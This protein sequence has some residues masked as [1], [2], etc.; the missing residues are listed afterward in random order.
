MYVSESGC[1]SAKG[2]GR[3]GRFLLSE[4][5]QR[6]QWQPVAVQCCLVRHTRGVLRSSRSL[7]RLLP[8][9]LTRILLHAD[10]KPQCIRDGKSIIIEGLHIDPGLFLLEFGDS[11]GVSPTS[12]GGGLDLASGDPRSSSSEVP[13]PVVEPVPISAGAAAEVQA[14]MAALQ[15]SAAANG[16]AAMPAAATAAEGQQASSRTAAAEA[17]AAAAGLLAQQNA[18]AA[19]VAADLA[20]AQPDASSAVRRTASFG[21]AVQRLH[22]GSLHRLH[23][24]W[25]EREQ[26]GSSQALLRPRSARLGSSSS[27][28]RGQAIFMLKSPEAEGCVGAESGGEAGS[29]PALLPS[30][31]LAPCISLPPVWEQGGRDAPQRCHSLPS[32]A[33]QRSTRPSES[34]QWASHQKPVPE[35]AA[36][37]CF[38]SGDTDAAPAAVAVMPPGDEQPPAAHAPSSPIITEQADVTEAS[39]A[40]AV[41][42]QQQQQQQGQH[43][44]VAAADAAAAAAAGAGPVFVPICLTVDDGEYDGMLDDW[45]AHQQ[46]ALG[47]GGAEGAATPAGSQEAALRL[48]LLQ[49]HLR[50]YGASGVPVVDTSDMAQALDSMHAY[51]LQC[52]ELALI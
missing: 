39:I 35:E 21:D 28:E 17:A 51:V 50:Q 18:A 14:H 7:K 19:A 13:V 22:Y 26:A 16:S 4:F 43:S 33:R 27:M 38:G 42:N 20:G 47:D 12:S 5:C 45:L 9:P 36:M 49:E 23:P 10:P 41:A 6:S 11:R 31:R 46:R 40:G 15:M 24:S 34:H 3:A 52:I 48:R 8:V 2:R 44:S 32:A 1:A 37:E 29:V 25:K 30:P